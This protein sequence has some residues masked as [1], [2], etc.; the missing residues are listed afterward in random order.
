MVEVWRSE[1][2][3]V[4]IVQRTREGIRQG[5]P[6]NVIK[7]QFPLTPGKYPADCTKIREGT[8]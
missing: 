6:L 5:L 1:I 7:A 3:Q 8:R 4:E 2:S